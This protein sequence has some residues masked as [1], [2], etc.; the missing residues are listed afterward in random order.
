MGKISVTHGRHTVF[1]PINDNGN[2]ELRVLRDHFP[3]AQG[4]ICRENKENVRELPIVGQEIILDPQVQQYDVYTCEQKNLEENINEGEAKQIITNLVKQLRGGK[5]DVNSTKSKKSPI[6]RTS[7]PI[8]INRPTGRPTSKTAKLQLGRM[9]KFEGNFIQIK[10]PHMAMV[11]L[12][13]SR[14]EEYSTEDLSTLGQ[15]EFRDENPWNSDANTFHIGNFRERFLRGFRDKDDQPC[16][17]WKYF[18]CRKLNVTKQKLYLYSEPQIK[19]ED[20]SEGI[21]SPKVQLTTSGKRPHPK[22]PDDGK[23]RKKQTTPLTFASL[24]RMTGGVSFNNLLSADIPKSPA[25]QDSK[26]TLSA[27]SHPSTSC[28]PPNENQT[29][30]VYRDIKNSDR[31]N[32]PLPIVLL[33]EDSNDTS[34]TLRDRKT[35]HTQDQ[36]VPISALQLDNP[37]GQQPS[38][39]DASPIG[40]ET[41]CLEDAPEV[42][43]F[44]HWIKESQYTKELSVREVEKRELFSLLQVEQR[45]LLDCNLSSFEPLE[46]GFRICRIVR[47]KETLL[48]IFLTP[49]GE[50]EFTFPST[51]L[52]TY[53]PHTLLYDSGYLNGCCGGAFGVG[54]IPYC[55]EECKPKIRWDKNGER[56]KEGTGYYWLDG[57]VEPDEIAVWKCS[58]TCSALNDSATVDEICQSDSPEIQK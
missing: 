5:K 43:V 39:E 11:T 44:Y 41:C 12:E 31:L 18:G 49:E 28:N 26:S 58:W 54:A 1:L 57:V 47:N 32:L 53:Q 19:F 37:T 21:D 9:H 56:F 4:L 45:D 15:K 17:L 22:E 25:P 23:R 27:A 34:G 38:G 30:R 42:E 33:E 6:P 36:V 16:D 24:R 13:L 3:E 40:I 50:K 46:W 2:V 51:D 48:H 20:P 35:D 14:S 55:T 8:Q 10:S 7:S 29:V 52:S